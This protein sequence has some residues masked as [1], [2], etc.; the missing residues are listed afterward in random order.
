MYKSGEEVI[1]QKYQSWVTVHSKVIIQI[2]QCVDR[3]G[4]RIL[5]VNVIHIEDVPAEIADNYQVLGS[6]D[7]VSWFLK[8]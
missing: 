8:K 6:Y 5:V 1:L 2:I 4:P 7:T 3:A